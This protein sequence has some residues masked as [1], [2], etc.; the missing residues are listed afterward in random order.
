MTRVGEV[1][2]EA[3]RRLRDGEGLF[4]RRFTVAAGRR[5]AA[6]LVT[7]APW[8]PWPERAARCEEPG[9]IASLAKVTIGACRVVVG[10]SLRRTASFHPRNGGQP[11]NNCKFARGRH[12][13]VRERPGGVALHLVSARPSLPA[14]EPVRCGGWCELIASKAED[15]TARSAVGGSSRIIW[16]LSR[17]SDCGCVLASVACVQRRERSPADAARE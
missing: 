1:H 16:E 10:S 2:V 5:P 9:V 17:L 12:P 15:C 7:S 8:V 3:A 14:E 6:A 11:E 13:V 4:A